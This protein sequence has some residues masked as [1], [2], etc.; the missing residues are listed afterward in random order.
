MGDDRSLN[1]LDHYLGTWEIIIDSEDAPFSGGEYTARWVK[2]GSFVEKTGY[3]SCG[4]DAQT[5]ETTT[6]ITHDPDMDRYRMWSFMT[7]GI[8]SEASASWDPVACTMT[9]V[10][11]HDGL[12]ITLVTSFASEDVQQWVMETAGPDGNVVSRMSGMNRRIGS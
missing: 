10:R 1:V 5:M 2:R 8:A 6:W 9:E 3:L 7:G 11:E 4:D 12:T